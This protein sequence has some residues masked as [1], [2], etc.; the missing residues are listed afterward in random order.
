M[1]KNILGVLMLCIMLFATGCNSLSSAPDEKS[2]Y[3]IKNEK[4]MEEI[5]DNPDYT[6]LK[7]LN[8][9]DKTNAYYK[10]IKSSPNPDG[11]KPY[12]N[13][14]VRVELVGRLISGEIFQTKEKMTVT[15][16]D[17][18]SE[19]Q[20]IGVVKGLQYALQKMTP[21]DKWELVL[22]HN[23]GY[24]SGRRG[25]IPPYSTLIFEVELLEIKKL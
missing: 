19:G 21:G 8:H 25:K 17:I 18:N 7:F 12:Q 4:Y 10:V 24:G 20:P 1:K 2:E 14:E 16:F 11:Q 3:Q 9:K 5:A 22:P 15:V 23:L 6:E 13:S